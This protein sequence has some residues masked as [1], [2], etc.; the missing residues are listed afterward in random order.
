MTSSQTYEPGDIVEIIDDEGG[1][2]GRPKGHRFEVQD[3]SEGFQPHDVEYGDDDYMQGPIIDGWDQQGSLEVE[4]KHVRL[5]HRAAD[6][7]TPTVADFAKA[8]DIGSMT[9]DFEHDTT[10][11]E[12]GTA[13]FT[14][15][16]RRSGLRWFATV[17][18]SS[19]VRSDT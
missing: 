8:L 1:S 10:E 5:V 3:Y 7:P 15:T 4:A 9:G 18:V 2:Y 12:D 19:V 6:V 16:D 11:F 14:F 13:Y 17:E